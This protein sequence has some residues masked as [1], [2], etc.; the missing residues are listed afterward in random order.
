M[1][2]QSPYPVRENIA[3]SH[4][5]AWGMIGS[6][7]AFWRANERVAMVREARAALV[8]EI[9]AGRKEALTPFGGPAHEATDELDAIIVDLVHRIV[10]DPQ[11]MTKR[12]F[13]EVIE[14][15][16]SL[17]QYLE[18]VAVTASSVI[19][20]T[21]NA[22]AGIAPLDLP[23]PL[24][25]EPT[26]QAPPDLVDDG[27][28]VPITRIERTTGPTGLPSVPNIARS[29]GAV[30]SARDLFFAAFRGHYALRDIPLAV[31]QA[32]AEFIASRVS[33]MN[34]CFY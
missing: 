11:R 5:L 26:G 34:E 30:P 28:W 4:Q 17:E 8:C 6:S 31:T 33:A 20:D 27:A 16:F 21:T 19:I 32:Q 13:D 15:G 10:T 7:G 3:E 18:V 24:P 2:E 25:G 23:E 29:L 12:I 14:A 1:F 22:G 9:C